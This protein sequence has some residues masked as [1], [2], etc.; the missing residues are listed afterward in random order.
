ME[1]VGLA[2]GVLGLAGLFSS[3]LE[4]VEKFD[5]YKNFGRDSRSLA[6]QFDADKHR[7]EQWG[8]AVGFEKGKLADHHHPALDDGQ[9]MA[10]V[11]KLLASIQDFCS[12]ADDSFSPQSTLAD[13][14]YLKD[15]LLYARQVQPRHGA[16]VD[17]K[18]RR[19]AWAL[20]GKTKRT[21]HVQTFAILVQY[22]YIVVPPDDPKSSLPGHGAHSYGPAPLHGSD[23][24][25]LITA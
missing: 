2:V 17:S 12:G 14:N 8:R 3:C 9:K 5:S 13:D 1:P 11:H 4:A 19:A 6:T 7:F 10:I 22:L 23:Q 15:G 24:N 21:G 16:P 20:T 25:P 18:W